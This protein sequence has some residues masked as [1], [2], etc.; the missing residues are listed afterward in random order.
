LLVDNRL[1]ERGED[2]RRPLEL[3][4]ARGGVDDPRQ[5]RIG[6]AQVGDRGARV[7]SS[8]AVASK[9]ALAGGAGASSMSACAAWSRR[10]RWRKPPSR[11]LAEDAVAGHDDRERCG[12]AWPTARAEPGAPTPAAISP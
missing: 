3:D 10:R 9:A 11:L 8:G 12:R 2:A 4:R 6:L 1:G 7:E 5:R